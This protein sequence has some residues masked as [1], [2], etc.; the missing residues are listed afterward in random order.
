MTR[1]ESEQDCEA[2]IAPVVGWANE[3]QASVAIDCLPIGSSGLDQP[4]PEKN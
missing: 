3:Q 1:F 4:A 2:A